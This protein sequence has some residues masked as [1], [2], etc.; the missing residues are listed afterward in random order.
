MKQRITYIVKDAT[1]G[2][3][4][5]NLDISR[6]S[7]KVSALEGAKEHQ[8]TLGLH[9]LPA[10]VGRESS[11]SKRSILMESKLRDVLASSHEL[12]IR[13]IS[14]RHYDASAPYVSRVNP[15]LH[16]FFSPLKDRAEYVLEFPF[17][18]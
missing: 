10:E 8:I 5:S 2:Y 15:G 1:Q 14:P 4:P 3:D 17:P 16:A 6:A 12:Y 18:T 13:W 9:E 11:S 7:I